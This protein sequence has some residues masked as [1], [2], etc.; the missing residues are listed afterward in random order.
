[1]DSVRNILEKF[2]NR[3]VQ[4]EITLTGGGKNKSWGFQNTEILR[5]LKNAVTTTLSGSTEKEVED[6][7]KNMAETRK[8]SKIVLFCN[9]Y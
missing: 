9:C 8:L 7:I 1:M 3:C 5:C 4:K 2:F 6:S